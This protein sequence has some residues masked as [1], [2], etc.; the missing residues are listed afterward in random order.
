MAKLKHHLHASKL[1][2]MK[3]DEA[4][5]MAE[6]HVWDRHDS[7][8][9][10]VPDGPPGLTSRF[11]SSGESLASRRSRSRSL[12]A[13]PAR[14]ERRRRSSTRNMLT[15]EQPL[16]EPALSSRS[17]SDRSAESEYRLM[18]CSIEASIRATRHAER[19]SQSAASAFDREATILER[20]L[21]TLMRLR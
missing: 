3:K 7:D 11:A 4:E 13:S 1:H 2:Y 5:E 20:S 14:N 10:D 12:A 18:V 6:A 21:D 8:E 15:I 17:D 16:S 19:L 9:E